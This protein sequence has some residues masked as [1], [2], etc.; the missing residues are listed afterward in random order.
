LTKR[1]RAEKRRQQKLAK[2]DRSRGDQAEEGNEYQKLS[3]KG[4][5]ISE[6][7]ELMK[8]SQLRL[9]QSVARVGLNNLRR[10]MITG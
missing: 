9:R 3:T 8:D 7:V 6:L 4:K 5:D 10:K 1:T 2:E